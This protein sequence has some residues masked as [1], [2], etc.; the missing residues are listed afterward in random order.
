[1]KHPIHLTFL[2]ALLL[3]GCSD[4]GN[5]EARFETWGE[6]YIEQGIPA[7]EFA[8]GWTVTYD[9]FLVVIDDVTLVHDDGDTAALDGG[10]RVYDLVVPGPH[11]MGFV[12][13]VAAGSWTAVGYATPVATVAAT[14]HA[15]VNDADLQMMRD[16]GYSVFAS[17]SA[18]DGHTTKTF[19]WGFT[20]PTVYARCVDVSGGQEIDGI[21]VPDGGVAP[22]QLTIHGD[23]LFYDDLQSSEA[24]LRFAHMAAADADDDGVVTLAELD[25][26]DL[27]SIPTSEGTYGVGA[28]NVNTLGDF[29]RASTRTLG[30]FNGEGHCDASA[31]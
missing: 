6:A 13:E 12:S 30:H 21:V 7:A 3:V 18:T 28:A 19:A 29:A 4:A 10:P 22:V 16:E 20:E 14:S 1:M 23:H 2:S 17:G 8:D 9:Q 5:G 11:E 24:G 26:V 25:A 27:S 31:Q 15:S